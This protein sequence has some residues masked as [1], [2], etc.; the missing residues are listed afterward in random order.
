MG[1][2]KKNWLT[3]AKRGKNT[4]SLSLQQ[5]GMHWGHTVGLRRRILPL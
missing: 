4:E 1:N 2:V 5:G 3:Y